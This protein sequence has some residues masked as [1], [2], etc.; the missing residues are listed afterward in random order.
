MDVLRAPDGDKTC[1]GEDFVQPGTVDTTVQ[2][3]IS[4]SL[5]FSAFIAFCVSLLSRSPLKP[6]NPA[7]RT[8]THFSAAVDPPATMEVP[9]RSEKTA[10][11]H[12]RLPTSAPRQLPWLDPSII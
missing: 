6:A 9:L 8:L 1:S 12:L 2:L 4:V 3:V 5:G 7:P 11:Q 10:P